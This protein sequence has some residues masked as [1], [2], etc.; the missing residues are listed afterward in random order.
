MRLL[1]Q[2]LGSRTVYLDARMRYRWTPNSNTM[3]HSS[4][5]SFSCQGHKVCTLGL[6]L[7]IRYFAS[8]N[9]ASATSRHVRG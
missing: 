6:V 7:H 1:Q 4:L 8:I 2:G 3:V 5:N 9:E